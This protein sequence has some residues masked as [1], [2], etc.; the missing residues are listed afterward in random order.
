MAAITSPFSRLV[1]GDDIPMAR[2]LTTTQG[3]CALQ[4]WE[5]K[6]VTGFTAGDVTFNGTNGREGRTESWARRSTPR[7]R[8]RR[9]KPRS[10]RAPGTPVAL[11]T[12]PVRPVLTDADVQHVA[13]AATA[14][15]SAPYTVVSGAVTLTLTPE[16]VATALKTTRQPDGT[17]LALALDPLALSDHGRHRRERLHPSAGRCAVRRQRRQHRLDRAVAGRPRARLQRARAPRSSRASVTSRRRSV[18]LHPDP[19]HR[20][21]AGARHPRGGR[22]VHDQPPVLCRRG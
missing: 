11:P 5:A 9:S 19:R 12:K 18:R 21:G 17:G 4:D 16:Q 8:R 14:V 2:P 13:D 10:R 6:N 1:S 7:P 15:L 20:V 3:R 22:H